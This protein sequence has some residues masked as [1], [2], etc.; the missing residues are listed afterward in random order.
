MG[1]IEFGVRLPVSGPLASLKAIESVA[2]DAEDLGYSSVWVHDHLTWTREMHEH[3]I[4][5]GASEAVSKDQNPDF[6]DSLSTLAYL[7]AKTKKV[8]L[9]VACMVLPCRNPIYLAKVAT[10]ID[11][12]SGGRF[13]LG[14]GTGSRA[15]R[16]SMEYEV[17][18]VPL[19]NRG[20]IIDEHI[21]AIRS[22]WTQQNASFQGKY[23]SFL[24][25]AIFPKPLQKPF[26]P[27]WIGGW[28][29][30][31]ADRAARLGDGWIPGWLSP[32]EMKEYVQYLLKKADEHG[33]GKHPFTYAVEKL[34]CVAKDSGD[35]MRTANLTVRDS[36]YT[37]ERN[38]ST[39]GDAEARHIFGSVSQVHN[40]IEEF[41]DAGVTHFELKFIYPS[42]M[43]L[44]KMMTL[45]SEEI[46]P[47]FN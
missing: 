39:F 23:V 26:L 42:L 43:L 36:L 31:S 38:V 37:Y 45:F 1:R 14:V 16:M 5:S 35:A 41:I 10:N 21:Q 33:R 4:S 13:I 32:S 25:A 47:S 46:I 11:H 8:K 40:R 27:I 6:Y 7:A 9:G 30:K 20:E 19:K 3:H 18:N 12:L 22:V 34:I 15:T 28:S 24:D 44:Q 29:L 17:L 2:S